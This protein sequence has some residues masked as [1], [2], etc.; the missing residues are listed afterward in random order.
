MMKNTHALEF[1]MSGSANLPD[2]HRSANP[3]VWSSI[4]YLRLVLFFPLSH[5]RD[6]LSKIYQQNPPE[7]VDK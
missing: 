5:A 4:P 6:Y 2:K 1:Q 7:K 3:K